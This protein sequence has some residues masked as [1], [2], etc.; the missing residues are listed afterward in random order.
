MNPTSG[1]HT[2]QSVT[3]AVCTVTMCGLAASINL[4]NIS[5]WL[6]LISDRQCLC[7]VL[8]LGMLYILLP[9]W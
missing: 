4:L 9:Y 8:S 6:L 2:L 3:G 5:A 7:N 1:N